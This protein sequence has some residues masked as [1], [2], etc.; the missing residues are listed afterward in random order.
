MELGG[1][2]V[3]TTS[4]RPELAATFSGTLGIVRASTAGRVVADPNPAFQPR[5]L[6]AVTVNVLPAPLG[7]AVTRRFEGV[8]ATYGI[9]VGLLSKIFNPVPSATAG[10]AGTATGGAEAKPPRASNSRERRVR[11][12]AKAADSEMTEV[13]T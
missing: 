5:S 7:S 9:T 10:D 3:S 13:T 2:Q 6:T 8:V 1:S 4:P 11:S 12:S